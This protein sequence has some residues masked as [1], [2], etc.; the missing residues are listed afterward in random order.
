MPITNNIKQVVD[1]LPDAPGVYFFKRGRQ[2][3]YIGKATSLRDRV[4]SY[5]RGDIA[6]A[7][8]NWIAKMVELVDVID[9]VV[10]DSV[11]EALLLESF[12]I[13][14][15]QPPYNIREK[16]DKSYLYVVFTK[17]A[18][19]QIIT[20]RGKDLA[21][22][23]NYK[24]LFG[25]FPHGGELREALK[26]IRR[27][28]PYRD[29]KCQPNQ[30]RPCFNAQIGLCPGVCSGGLT[31]REY[32]RT[33][34][35]LALFFQGRKA[36]VLKNLEREMKSLAKDQKFEA[37]DQIKRKIF[38]LQ[39]IHDVALIKRT[40]PQD[41]TLAAPGEHDFRL[42]AYDVAHLSGKN[43]VGVMVVSH[44]AELVKDQYRKFKL[45]GGSANK[46]DDTGNLLEILNRRL[47]HAEWPLPNAIVVDGGTA[48][49]NVAEKILHGYKLN[50]PVI[51]VVK[52]DKHKARELNGP[53]EIVEKY[54]DA[55]I[56][57]NAEAHRFAINYHRLLRG[58]ML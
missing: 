15:H 1:K 54:R 42:E 7:R 32:G 20:V 48:Q 27:I 35:N 4:R 51:S 29:E 16:D 45:R 26:I 3:L 40:S 44:N 57:L 43:T 23:K 50:I 30:G 47:K 52:D 36:A 9:H 12:Q 21:E 56:A 10:T 28:F 19:P 58:R 24:Y 17:E 37:A 22:S 41:F 34:R 5:F 39:H 55:I 13:K 38:A 11:L 33:V 53:K 25:P 18:F 31:A 49:A 46:A 8:S 6:S 2:I 14:K